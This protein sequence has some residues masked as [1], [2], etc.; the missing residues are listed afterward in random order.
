MV[1]V[2]IS[3]AVVYVK[4][5]DVFGNKATLLA[6]VAHECPVAIRLPLLRA[7]FLAVALV[8]RGE[9]HGFAHDTRA[10]VG[11]L[12]LCYKPDWT[13]T[14]RAI[15]LVCHGLKKLAACPAWLALRPLALSPPDAV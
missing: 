7:V 9:K 8:A 13:A 1:V 11:P 3:V 2:A 12:G 4:L 6:G 5:A 15:L 10:R 14:R